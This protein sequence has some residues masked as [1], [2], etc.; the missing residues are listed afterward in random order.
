MPGRRGTGGHGVAGGG[1]AGATSCD[2]STRAIFPPTVR[3]STGTRQRNA[4]GKMCFGVLPERAPLLCELLRGDRSVEPEGHVAGLRQDDRL[5]VVDAR[6]LRRKTEPVVAGR[7][8]EIELGRGEE[9]LVVRLRQRRRALPAKRARPGRCRLRSARR[10]ST[11]S[12]RSSDRRGVSR[13]KGYDKTR[14]GAE[15]ERDRMGPDG[16]ARTRQRAAAAALPA[17]TGP[18]SLR[19]RGASG[20]GPILL[21]RRLGALSDR[22]GRVRGGVSGP[23][24]V[25]LPRLV[26]G[27]GMLSGRPLPRAGRPA[28]N[29]RPPPCLRKPSRASPAPCADAPRPRD[30]RRPVDRSE[31]P[32]GARPGGLVRAVRGACLPRPLETEPRSLPAGPAPFPSPRRNL[33]R[34]PAY[35]FVVK[36]VDRLHPNDVGCL[37]G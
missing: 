4:T 25:A 33:S 3:P 13:D 31:R 22:P 16:E 6:A 9:D 36:A 11:R 8:G 28:G 7:V 15:S 26:P 17:A 27:A 18:I 19:G 24:G 35:P 23:P 12:P 1:G 30:H 34:S 29:A 21:R 5:E 37:H 2:V 14:R 10:G 20:I 32:A